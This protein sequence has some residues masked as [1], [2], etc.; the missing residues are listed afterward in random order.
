MVIFLWGWGKYSNCVNSNNAAYFLKESIQTVQI[1]SVRNQTV[2]I[3]IVWIETLTIQIVQIQ[4]V[5]ILIV[6]IQIYLMDKNADY[7]STPCKYK[8]KKIRYVLKLL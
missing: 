4:I 8:W 7:M 2:Q 5:W 1:Q 3:Q 6:R